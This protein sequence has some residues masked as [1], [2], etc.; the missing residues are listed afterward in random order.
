MKKT[1]VLFAALGVGAAALAVLS[2]KMTKN[3]EKAV[4][5]QVPEAPVSEL[6]ENAPEMAET[7]TV[8]PL[9]A[10]FYTESG[11][12]WHADRDCFYIKTAAEIFSDSPEG[13]R[14]AGKQKP[15]S[16]CAQLHNAE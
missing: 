16:R 15:C 12:V 13:A 3:E 5:E 14:L 11:T 10:C 2:R 9:S 1:A 6:P 4:A 7:D 8:M